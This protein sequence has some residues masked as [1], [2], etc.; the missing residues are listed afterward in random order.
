MGREREFPSFRRQSS[1]E[2]CELSNRAHQSVTYLPFS[3]PPYAEGTFRGNMHRS[4]EWNDGTVVGCIKLIVY[5]RLSA[6]FSLRGRGFDLDPASNCWLQ[7]GCSI[8]AN[9]AHD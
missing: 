5:C 2:S 7:E 3:F 4:F 6:S 1:L 8:V 9:A